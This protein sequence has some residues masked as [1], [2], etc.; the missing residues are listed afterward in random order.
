MTLGVRRSG[1]A[2]S[3]FP[4]AAAFRLG[5]MATVFAALSACEQDGSRKVDDAA[6]R[7]PGL[8]VADAAVNGRSDRLR[9]LI[10]EGGKAGSGSDNSLA[11]GEREQAAR[12]VSAC[13]DPSVGDIDPAG[14]MI[15]LKLSMNRDGT[16]RRLEVLDQGKMAD[17][18]SLRAFAESAIKAVMRCTPFNLPPDQYVQWQTLVMRFVAEG[19]K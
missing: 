2:T 1:M 10:E 8:G 18:R 11:R 12:Q 3:H 5:A 16:V 13:W 7:L 15:R 19:A 17:S 9:I 4:K 6:T 14:S